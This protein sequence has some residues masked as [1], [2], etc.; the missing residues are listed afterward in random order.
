[1]FQTSPTTSSRG[2]VGTV[3]QDKVSGAHALLKWYCG[4]CNASIAR[5]DIRRYVVVCMG[6]RHVFPLDLQMSPVM[7]DASGLR[8]MRS[9]IFRSTLSCFLHEQRHQ[10]GTGFWPLLRAHNL[11]ALCTCI[12]TKR[13][14]GPGTFSKFQA[15]KENRHLRRR[16]E[17]KDRSY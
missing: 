6:C 9:S 13:G 11:I 14:K 12:S 10:C 4:K 7:N 2:E 15:F 3:L 8:E 17:G 16:S 1:M 5:S